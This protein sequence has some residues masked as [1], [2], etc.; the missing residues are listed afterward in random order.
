MMTAWW[1]TKSGMRIDVITKYDTECSIAYDII[2]EVKN[3]TQFAKLMAGGRNNPRN[4]PFEDVNKILI[5]HGFHHRAPRAGSS[6]HTYSHPVLIDIVTVPYDRPVKA[7][8]VMKML[9]WLDS[10]PKRS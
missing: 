4:V 3:V 2:Y 6:H 1:P 9:Q 10:V 8:Y 7:Y 5:N